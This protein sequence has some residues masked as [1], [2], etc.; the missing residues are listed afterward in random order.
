[1]PNPFQVPRL[2]LTWIGHDQD[3][4]GGKSGDTQS[5]AAEPVKNKNRTKCIFSGANT[6]G[7]GPWALQALGSGGT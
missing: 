7:V 1:M 5:E 6:D 4:L 3:T 2:C